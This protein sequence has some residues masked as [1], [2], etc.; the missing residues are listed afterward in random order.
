M[1]KV[2]VKLMDKNHPMLS[3]GLTIFTVNGPMRYKKMAQK[4]KSIQTQKEKKSPNK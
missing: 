2:T 4:S 3:Q 1:A